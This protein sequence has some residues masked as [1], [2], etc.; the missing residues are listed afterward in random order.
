VFAPRNAAPLVVTHL[1]TP[2]VGVKAA[3][4]NCIRD[5]RLYAGRDFSRFNPMRRSGT[6]RSIGSESLRNT[7]RSRPASRCPSIAG[8]ARLTANAASAV[9][10][11]VSFRR[12][13]YTTGTNSPV[14]L[15]W[16]LGLGMLATKAFSATRADR[17]APAAATILTISSARLTKEPA[18]ERPPLHRE[19]R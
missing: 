9:S 15:R 3:A 1:N 13:G 5:G 16:T 19:S 7:M 10:E 6:G 11:L 18:A 2:I 12:D 14:V 4:H 17:F 8:C